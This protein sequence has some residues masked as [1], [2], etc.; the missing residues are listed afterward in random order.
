MIQPT[1]GK[2]RITELDVLRGLALFGIL[3]INLYVFNAPYGYLW[4][5]YSSFGESEGKVQEWVFTFF[6][7]KSMFIYAF[8][9]G[10]G[11]YLQWQ[12]FTK[13]NGNFQSF[14]IR[15]MLVLALFGLAHVLFFWY[16]DILLPYAL[17][18]IVLLFIRQ[19]N[20][21]LLLL[22]SF[23]LFL[24]PAIAGLLT[25]AFGWPTLH[26]ILPFELPRII[27]IYQQGS[28]LD[29]LKINLHQYASL[30]NEKLWMYI[31]RE[32]S[33]FIAGYLAA[34]YRLLHQL[35]K[36]P[37]LYMVTAFATLAGCLAFFSIR[38]ELYTLLNMIG[39]Q[40]MPLKIA[41]YVLISDGLQGLSYITLLITAF[42]FNLVSKLLHIF[43]YAGKMAL[44]NYLMQT[45]IAIFIFSGFGLGYYGSLSPSTLLF[46]TVGIYTFQVLF[47]ALYLRYNTQGP[48]ERI[49][50]KL[51]YKTEVSGKMPA[52]S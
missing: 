29:I 43:S 41:L 9:F 49:W 17:M 25:Y 20:D 45:L 52:V 51:S 31:P 48:L 8:L 7:G 26:A 5:F 35:K 11:F 10:F 28:Y 47:S 38:S 23:L 3:A 33:L 18:G 50:R 6:G 2:E 36:K 37:V 16:G 14:Y 15:R 12:R 27:E 21:K 24:G 30:K 39:P 22:F 42:Q 19:W 1:A 32:L 4:D 46:L 34:K 13:K 40:W 44:T